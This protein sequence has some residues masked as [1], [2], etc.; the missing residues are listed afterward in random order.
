MQNASLLEQICSSRSGLLV[1]RCS[2][3]LV[4]WP[5]EI[6]YLCSFFSLAKNTENMF[7]VVTVFKEFPNKG[8]W[9]QRF[10]LVWMSWRTHLSPLAARERQFGEWRLLSEVK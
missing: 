1:S 9:V 8:F 10:D 5:S 6:L 4:V 3:R 7:S 2:L